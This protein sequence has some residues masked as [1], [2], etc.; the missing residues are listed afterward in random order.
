[1]LSGIKELA[2]EVEGQSVWASN[3]SLNAWHNGDI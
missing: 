1:M 2:N 3:A